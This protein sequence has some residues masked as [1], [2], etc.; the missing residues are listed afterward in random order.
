VDVA[1]ITYH[2]AYLAQQQDF[3]RILLSRDE[4]LPDSQAAMMTVRDEIREKKRDTVVRYAMACIHA[5]RLFNQVAGDPERHSDLLKLIVKSI[6]PKDEALLKAVAPH[7][8]WIA[9]DGLPNIASIM[10]Q[11]DFWA[12][13]F[14]MVETKIPQERVIDQSIARDAARRLDVEK[15]FG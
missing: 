14:K 13:T 4:I 10:Q 6:F 9:E 8:E 5:A 1:E 7:W 12:D 11:Q 15:P 2:L 3:C